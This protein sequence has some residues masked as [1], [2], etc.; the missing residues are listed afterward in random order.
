MMASPSPW[1]WETILHRSLQFLHVL[2]A[3]ALTAFVLNYLFMDVCMVSCTGREKECL[4]LEKRAV[5]GSLEDSDSK[6]CLVPITKDTGSLSA[7]FFCNTTY[8]MGRNHLAL[9]ASPCGDRGLE[10]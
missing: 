9:F 10:N 5:A 1:H 8:C 7:G 2:Q 4:P 3:E 6:A